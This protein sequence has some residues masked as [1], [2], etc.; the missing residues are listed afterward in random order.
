MIALEISKEAL[1]DLFADLKKNP[2]M[3]G[4]S[5]RYEMFARR[6]VAAEYGRPDAVEWALEW[7]ADLMTERKR[8]EEVAQ[9][10]ASNQQTQRD[11]HHAELLKGRAGNPLY[12]SFLDTVEDPSKWQNNV[13]YFVFHSKRLSEFNA[14]NVRLQDSDNRQSFAQFV[15]DYADCHLANRLKGFKKPA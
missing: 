7:H 15:R 6:L 2:P 11:Y 12:Q 1:E 8:L 10:K 4:G 3:W 13:D 5:F 14:L 9:K